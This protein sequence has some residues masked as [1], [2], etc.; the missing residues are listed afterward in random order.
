MSETRWV[1]SPNFSREVTAQS[2]DGSMLASA[3]SKLKNVWE[4]EHICLNN[5]TKLLVWIQSVKEISNTNQ[6]YKL[7]YSNQK[8]TVD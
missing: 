8:D 6:G 7:I 2:Q 4:T 3:D 1:S 5:H